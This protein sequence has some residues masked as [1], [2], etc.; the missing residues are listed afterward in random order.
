VIGP[1]AGVPDAAEREV[2]PGHVH[3]GV[4]DQGASRVGAG[5][6][7]RLT[8]T[9]YRAPYSDHWEEEP[10]EWMLDRPVSGGYG[11]GREPDAG[12]SRYTP[13]PQGKT[14]PA[15]HGLTGV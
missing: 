12:V 11:I 13:F 9:L 2:V 8:R 10:W 15:G 5:E 1:H 6:G 3:Q 4:V 14:T 7:H